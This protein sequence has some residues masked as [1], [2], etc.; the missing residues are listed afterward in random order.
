[1]IDKAE[2]KDKLADLG[3]R[4]EEMRDYL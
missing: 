3:R 2:I 4:I 1:M